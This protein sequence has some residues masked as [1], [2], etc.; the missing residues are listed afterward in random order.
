[1]GAE[2]TVGKR[3]AQS[4]CVQSRIFF[5]VARNGVHVLFAVVARDV[6]CFGVPDRIEKEATRSVRSWQF[7]YQIHMRSVRSDGSVL[8]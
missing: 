5:A 6:L 3:G 8:L 7:C 1:L 2:H 4:E